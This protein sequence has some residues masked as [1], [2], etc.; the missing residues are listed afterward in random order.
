LIRL[1]RLGFYV[2]ISELYSG[3]FKLNL[4]DTF[5]AGEPLA[6]AFER[7]RAARDPAVLGSLSERRD[8]LERLARLLRDNQAAICEAVDRDFGGRSPAETRL[9]VIFN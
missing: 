4:G 9:L 6:S 8:R 1:H 2:G 7:Q 3:N 5:T